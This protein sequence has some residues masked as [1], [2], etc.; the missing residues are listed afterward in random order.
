M[1]STRTQWL[2]LTKKICN[3][4]TSHS[5]GQIP[6]LVNTLTCLHTRIPF[7]T[8]LVFLKRFFR[9]GC[10]MRWRRLGVELKVGWGRLRWESTCLESVRI[11]LSVFATARISSFL[12]N[13]CCLRSFSFIYPKSSYPPFNSIDFVDMTWERVYVREEF[14]SV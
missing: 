5:H 11:S 13:V 4:S 2:M 1:H 6:L 8:D 12:I 14:W 10:S 3:V 9:L 7:A